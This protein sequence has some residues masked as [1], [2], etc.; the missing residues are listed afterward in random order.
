M[1]KQLQPSSSPGI[2]LER[3]LLHAVARVSAFIGRHLL[4]R[5][6]TLIASHITGLR[7]EEEAYFF[8][9][10]HGYTVIA[11]RWRTKR[12]RG[13]LDFVAWDGSTL[14]FI[15]VKTRTQR[16]WAPAESQVDDAKR[17]ILRSMAIVFARR[18]K[19]AHVPRRGDV[20]SVYLLGDKVECELH[21]D[22]FRVGDPEPQRKP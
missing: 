19:L 8:L 2:H 16:D 11:R 6:P 4:R 13:E 3:R 5:K 21:R 17:R 15:E 14:C 10:R 9:R 20:V 7:G 12:L 18:R 22:W 1:S